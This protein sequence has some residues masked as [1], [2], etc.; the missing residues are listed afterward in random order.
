M[1]ITG[2]FGEA[3]AGRPV[4][5]AFHDGLGRP[6]DGTAAVFPIIQTSEAERWRPIG[7]GFF[8]SNNGLFAT[9]KHVV[10][11]NAGR[12][13]QHL[14]GIQLLRRENRFIIRE[15]IKIAIHPQADVA[16]GFLFDRRFAEEGVQTVNKLFA[17]TR[18]IPAIGTKVATFAFPKSEHAGSATEFKLK[19]TTGAVD[20]TIE[21]YYPDGRDTSMLPGRC[22]QTSMDLLAG[23][24]GGPVAFGEGNVFGINSTGMQSIPVSFISSIDDLFDL[25]V[26]NVQ[27]QDGEVKDRIGLQELVER[28]L[29]IV[30]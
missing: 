18:S 9:A 10:L 16:I 2:R 26:H 5:E 12:L 30:R 20:G 25:E 11:D 19:F 23:A 8:I 29:V 15:A 6:A 1:N 17:L 28:G 14:A 27:F 24:S 4:E 21:A 22:F 3:D 7:T 13:I